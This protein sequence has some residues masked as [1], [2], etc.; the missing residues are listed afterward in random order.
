MTTPR[1][2]KLDVKRTQGSYRD[3]SDRLYFIKLTASNGE[4]LGVGE[5][6]PFRSAS[7]SR[8]AWLRAMLEVL[9]DEGYTVRFT[10]PEITRHSTVRVE[11][12]TANEL[13]ERVQAR[14]S[15][16][17]KSLRDTFSDRRD[18]S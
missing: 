13:L 10:S 5:T 15:E 17:D 3:E 14:V 18:E 2:A 16:D 9:E 4:T 8:E 12:H 1:R 11:D 6:Q 7:E